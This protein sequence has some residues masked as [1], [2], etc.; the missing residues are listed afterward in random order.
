MEKKHKCSICN[1]NYSS[2][3]SLY[4][5]KRVYHTNEKQLTNDDKVKDDNLEQCKYCGDKFKYRTNK[6]V[7]EFR[8]I[9]IPTEL[10][11]PNDIENEEPCTNIAEKI[12]EQQEIDAINGILYNKLQTSTSNKLKKTNKKSKEAIKEK[13]Q[14]NTSTIK[15]KVNE[16]TS[17]IIII[18]QNNKEPNIK[19]L[20]KTMNVDENI[21][22]NI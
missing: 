16:N 15:T 18:I 5:H 1:K 22:E 14:N 13:A 10:R 17:T 3:S 9:Y 6:K 8:C 20:L 2:A 4:N 21:I 7:H 12:R 19:N 11:E